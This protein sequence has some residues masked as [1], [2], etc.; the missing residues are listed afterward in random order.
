MYRIISKA[1]L[2]VC[3]FTSLIFAINVYS[4]D[5]IANLKLEKNTIYIFSRG[6]QTK[7]G[8][9][10]EKF[11]SHDRK[12]THVGIGF[13]EHNDIRIYHVVDIDSSQTALVITDLKSFINESVYY[14]S[15][16]KCDNNTI[17]FKNL[18]K[19]CKRYSSKKIY[20]DF[21]FNLN[22]GNTLYCSEFCATVLNETNS[23]IFNFKPKVMQLDTFYKTVLERDELLY[24]P[25]DFFEDDNCFTKIYESDFSFTTD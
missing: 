4:Q 12:I 2:I 22:D 20:F 24:Y 5:K 3:H 16:W 13:W 8:I 23:D 11:N 15:I 14:L 7:S 10:A 9:I 25:V 21:S 1:I 18:K 6:T 17:D 19:I